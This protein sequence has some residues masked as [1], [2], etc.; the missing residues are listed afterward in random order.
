[1]FFVLGCFGK[2]DAFSHENA[3]WLSAEKLESVKWL[4]A[5]EG[6]LEKV[7]ELL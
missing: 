4:L 2:A 1:M 3:A 5:D 7:K 6:I